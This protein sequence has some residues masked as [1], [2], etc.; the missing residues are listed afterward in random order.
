MS[1][2]T[3][4][5]YRCVVTFRNPLLRYPI[6][7]TPVDPAPS[8]SVRARVQVPVCGDVPQPPP[9]PVEPA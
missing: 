8:V 3:P 5:R 9:I 6:G 4:S 1:A 7:P 2:S